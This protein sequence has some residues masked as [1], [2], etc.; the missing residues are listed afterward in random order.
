MKT[1]RFL[2]LLCG[3]VLTALTVFWLW[4]SGPPEAAPAS[5]SEKVVQAIDAAAPLAAETMVAGEAASEPPPAAFGAWA[6]EKP[7]QPDFAKIDAFD[8]WVGRWKTA[9]PDERAK[10]TGEGAQLAGARRAEFKALIITN[11]RLALERAVPRVVRQDLPEEIVA[12]LETPISA[13]GDYDVYLGRPAPGMPL[14]AEGLALRYFKVGAV[15][16]QA[17]VYGDMEP[18]M[19]RKQIPL[20]GVAVDRPMAVAESPVRQ[21]EV[22][23]K[24][25][26]GTVVE[27]TCPVS[28]KTTVAVAKGEAVTD[29][30]PTIEV[31]E[32]IITLCNGAHVPV[33]DEKYRVL[34]QA[35]GPGGPGFFMDAFPGTSSRAIGNFRCLYIRATY[36]DQ[37]APP[38]TEDQAVED[39]TNTTR[40]FLESSYGKMTTTATV[41]P[42]IVLPQTLKW[43]IDKDA[44]VNGLGVLQTQARAEARKLGYDSTQYDCIILRVNGGLRSGSSWGGGDSVWLG[45]GGMDVINHECGHSLGVGHANYWDVTDGVP[46]GNGANQEYGNGFDVMGGGGGFSAHYN[47]TTKR[48]LGW[49]PASYAHFPKTNGV[50]GLHAFDQSQLEEGKRYALNVSK[51]GTINYDIEYHANNATLANQAL[52]LYGGRLIDTTPGSAGGKNDG[53]IQLGRT[54]SDLE[55]DQHFTFLSKNDTSPPSIDI[56]Y[57]R[58]PFPSN[59]VPAATLA[60]TAT[61]VAVGGSVTFSATANDADGDP[62]AYH[63]QF[64]D[65]VTGNNSAVFT[66]SFAATSQVSAQ[67]T[68]SDMKGGS[69][70][71][72]VM[73]TVGSPSTKTIAGTVTAGG[74]PLAGVLVKEGSNSCYTGVDGSYTIGNVTTG[75]RT[76]SAEI[77]GYTFTPGFTNPLSVTANVSNANWTATGSTFV[78][79]A[80]TADA[81]EGG[82]NG[83]FRLTRTGSTAAD[84]VVS[85]APQGGTATKTTD[86]TFAPDFVTA[87]PYRTFTIPAGSATLDVVVAAVNDTAQEGPETI[88]LQMVSGVGYFSATANAAVM[89]VGDNDTVLPQVA[90]TAPDPYAMEP[91]DAGSFVFTRTGSTV[92]AL[93]LAVVWSGT[94]VNGTDYTTLPATVVIPSGQSSVT[95]AVTPLNDSAI[96]TPEDAIATISSNAA[97]VRDTAATTA[98]VTL[99]DDDTPQV[100]VSV[101]DASAAEAGQDSGMFLITRTGSTAAALKVYFGLSGSASHGTDYAA[102]NGELTIPAGA[103]SA[104]VV[105]TPYHDDLGEGIETVTLAVTTFNNA[106]SVGEAFQASL[107]LTDNGDIPVVAVRAGTVGVE[108]GANATVVFRAIGSGSGNVTVN[109]TVS[110]TA[111]SGTDFA[112]LSGTVSVPANG[113][114]DVTVSIPATNDVAAEPTETVVVKITPSAAYRVYNDGTAEAAIRDNDSGAERVMVSAYNSSPAETGAATGQ[115]YISRAVGTTGALTVNYSL[116][117]TATTGTDY[118]GLTGSVIIP[119]TQPGEVVTFTPVDDALAEGTET[120]TLTVLAAAGYSVDRPASATL[121]IADSETPAVSVGFQTAAST[122]SEIPGGNGEY[123]D[124][125]VT[126]SAA[127]ASTITVQV[128]GGSGTSAAGDDVDWA[129]VDAANGNAFLPTATLTFAPGVTSRNV[130]VRVKNDGIIEPGETAVLE[131]RAPLAA[132]LSPTNAKHQLWIFDGTIPNLATEERWN[133]TAVY[134]NQTWSGSSPNYTGYLNGFTPSQGVADN[135]SR[136]ITGQIV[137]PTTGTYKFWIAS[138]DASRLYLSTNSTAANKVQIGTV[139]GWVDF[140]VW[141]TQ[142]GQ[143]SANINLVAGQSYY[144]EVQHQEGGGGDHVSVA[145]QGPGFTRTPITLGTPESTAPRFVRL[146]TAASTR[147]ESDGTEPLL[148]AVLDRPAGSTAIAVSYTV[149]GTATAGSDF[150]LAPGTLTFAAGEQVKLIS[151]SIL[152]DAIGETPEAIVV[153]LANPSGAQLGSPSTHVITVQDADTPVIE[154]IFAT[155]T[156]AMSSGTVVGTAFATPATGRSI[157]GWTIVAGNNGNAF[158]INA[159]GQVSLVTPAALPN[160]GGVQLVVR[161]TD[162]TGS[163]GD[164]LVNIVCNAPAN[165]VVEQRWT[166]SSPFWNEVWSGTPAYTGTLAT[167]TTTQGVADNYSRRLTGYLKPATTGDYT[168][169]IAGDDDCRLYLGSNGSPSSKTQIAA[170]NGYTGFQSWDSQAGQK[171]VVIPLVAGKVYWLEAHQLEGGGGDH[172]SVAW[173]GPGI[174]RQALPTSVTFPNVVGL[175]FDNPPVPPTLALTSPAAGSTHDSGVGIVIGATV[176]GGSQTITTVNFYQGAAL[177]GSDASA[178]YSVTWSNAPSG[179]HVLTARAVYSG[180]GVTSSG[181]AI[182]VQG[183]DAPVFTANP[184]TG[185]NATEYIAYNGTIAGSATDADPGDTLTYTKVS[186]PAWLGVAANGALSGTPPTGAAGMNVFTVRATDNG[187]MT[188]EATLNITVNVGSGNGVWINLAGGTWSTASNWNGIIA[189]GSGNTADF[190]TLD[191]TTATTVTLDTA[192]TIGNL[193]FDDTGASGDV[194]WTLTGST[195]TLAGGATSTIATPTAA[196][197]NSNLAGANSIT[198]TGAAILTLGGTN[199]FSGGINVQ[200]GSVSASSSTALGAGAILAN[201]SYGSSYASGGNPFLAITATGTAVVPNYIVLANPGSSSYYA[202]QKSG[203]GSSIDLSGAIS[204]GGTNMVFQLDTPNSGDSTTSYTLSGNNTFAG[205]LRLNRG[206][207]TLANANAAGTATVFLQSNANAAGNLLFSNSFTLNNNI[208]FGTTANNAIGTGTNDVVLAGTVTSNV[209]W[210]KA[211]TGK[212]TLAGSNAITGTVTAGAGTL[213]IDGTLGSGAV[214]TSSGATLAGTGTLGG[215]TT[216]A[217]GGTLAPG[218][219]GIGTLTVNNTLTLGGTAAFEL[220]KTGATLT[221]DRVQGLTGV[222]YGGTLNITATG[223]ALA[224]GNTFTLFNATSYS[225]LFTTINLPALGAGLA[226]NT[227]QLVVNG[228]V[229]VVPVTYTLTYNADSNGTISG[230]TP[231]TVNHGTSGTAVTA[232]PN[233]GYHFVN[234]SDGGTTN[235]RTDA[236]VTEDLTA[237]ANFAID[238]FTLTYNAGANGTLSGT[239]PQ[240]VNHGASGSAVTAV[241]NSGYGFTNWS[242]G[243]TSNPRTDAKVTANLTVTANFTATGPGPLLPPWTAGKIGSVTAEV[244]ATH[245]NGTFNVTGGGAGISGKNDNFYFA[246]QPWSGDGTITARVV[247]LQNTGSAAKAGVMIRESTATGSR[248]VFVGLTPASGVQWVRRSSTGGNSSTTTSTGK[249]APYW[250]R[251][252]RTGNTFTSYISPTGIVWIQLASANISMNANYSLG[253][254]T[255]SGA[256]GTPN[257]SVFDNVSVSNTAT[258]PAASIPPTSLPTLGALTLEEDTVSFAGTGDPGSTWLLQESTDFVNWTPL[259]T[260][261]LIDGSIQHSEADDR[262]QQRFFRLQASP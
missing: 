86:Y 185:T 231:Q 82:A 202:I 7:R 38:N 94:A 95:I 212:L 184:M 52:V 12:S 28:G 51:N 58:G 120:V 59:Q 219:S 146:A 210:T 101:P 113:T 147:L 135:Y 251:L 133:N 19:S 242:D 229:S 44:E 91:A 259:Q 154:T 176:A 221:N 201:S 11:P 256:S 161:A 45:W 134:T 197:I 216:V 104:P 65:G 246:S 214:T 155:A 39:M 213:Q 26:A 92:A 143:A 145:W 68:V 211:G 195:L 187:G 233:T 226:W 166:G 57:Q 163:T 208:T 144:M 138:D 73:I 8:E 72:S 132:A 156:S 100:T 75:T 177:I 222:T 204:G 47:T 220:N 237:T 42:L 97:Y 180:G 262:L 48:N 236:T 235:P 63:W 148:M 71:R 218:S 103:V 89:T 250:V 115:F 174:S 13:T 40:F 215:A 126:L 131:L 139:S 90:V 224:A 192:R 43:Y 78:T 182:T 149:G 54:Y 111:T 84:L 4:R 179:S 153:S 183:N 21:L 25:P 127:S 207:V 239:T 36:P 6:T 69:V 150:T 188:A 140:Q 167:F 18:V 245:L 203:A 2:F 194:A 119:D 79:L 37:M 33:M 20:R 254:A 107:N 189:D 118:T 209:A 248:S 96:E 112:A 129:F 160:P 238:T 85:V 241:P 98:T 93:N 165:R 258:G 5:P 125:P 60:A 252:T 206:R 124:I 102:L 164:G 158:A 151:N 175:N 88:T 77:A 17:Y 157:T 108:G 190:S 196:T 56:A 173:Q 66:R 74:V 32:R 109:Y 24:I 64:S 198:K 260:I 205:T 87:D 34:I 223:D 123:R 152:A 55:S 253:L 199:T 137:A 193:S 249:T 230:T 29:D 10:M 116:S 49:L 200:Q 105:I 225:G 232:V 170:V 41:T 117:G 62:L 244:D 23:E 178:P 227:N 234:W 257:A 35:A 83:N 240:T 141:D 30:T 255:C 99:A 181:V 50:Y 228:T 114:N 122:T 162:N 16:Y 171:S 3:L 80:K 186:G 159:A 217:A 22:G 136:R 106:Y 70:R 61:S 110:G 46:Y 53:G 172:V 247:S 191:L 121:E 14:P 261:T 128:V 31:G 169:W 67:L 243:S 130:R 142:G 1:R 15:D 81:T 27:D 9:T 76:L 168:F